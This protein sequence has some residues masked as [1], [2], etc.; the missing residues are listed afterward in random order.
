LWRLQQTIGHRFQCGGQLALRGLGVHLHGN[1]TLDLVVVVVAGGVEFG[2]QVVDQVGVGDPGQLRRVVVGPEGGQDL[3]GSLTKS[4][5]KVV[6][7]P[8]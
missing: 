7:L 4:R 6:S 2:P 1:D 8:G 3:L 5:M